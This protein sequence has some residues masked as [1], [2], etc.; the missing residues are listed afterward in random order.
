MSD[1]TEAYVL[2]DSQAVKD[3]LREGSDRF[4]HFSYSTRCSCSLRSRR[5]MLPIIWPLND[6]AT[7]A[8]RPSCCGC[9]GCSGSRSVA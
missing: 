9:F 4:R 3:Q 8:L 2:E 7:W 6:L 5:A 1:R